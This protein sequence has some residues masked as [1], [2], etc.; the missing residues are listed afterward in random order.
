MRDS[1]EVISAK[2][3]IMAS[4][5]FYCNF[6]SFF[7][8]IILSIVSLLCCCCEKRWSRWD[9]TQAR[10]APQWGALH[11]FSSICSLSLMCRD[12]NHTKVSLA[13]ENNTLIITAIVLI[14]IITRCTVVIIIRSGA[15]RSSSE[16]QHER[17]W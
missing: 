6:F 16:M 5:L 9:F 14:I 1:D 13:P 8:H 11:C 10:E 2:S 7:Y 3:F 15:A 12:V 4:L 17:R